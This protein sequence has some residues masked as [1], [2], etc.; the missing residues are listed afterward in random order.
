MK[1]EIVNVIAPTCMISFTILD[2]IKA[3]HAGMFPADVIP[4]D[5]LEVQWGRYYINRLVSAVQET[6]LCWILF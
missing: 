2:Y 4:T 6:Y 5:V 1:T 3:Q